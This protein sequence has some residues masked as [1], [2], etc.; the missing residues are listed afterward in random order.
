MG[1]ASSPAAAS[2]PSWLM[3]LLPTCRLTQQQPPSHQQATA[4]GLTKRPPL[5][6]L[7]H[8]QRQQATAMSRCQCGLS[9]LS[10]LP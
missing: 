1:K 8:V 3:D 9:C 10:T 4:S 2:K 7:E 5:L 6:G